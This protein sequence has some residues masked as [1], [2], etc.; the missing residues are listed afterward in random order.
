MTVKILSFPLQSINIRKSP[1]SEKT[2]WQ[3][4]NRTGQELRRCT[5]RLMGFS[6]GG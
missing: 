1:A 4:N 2:D 5:D 6:E 3:Q